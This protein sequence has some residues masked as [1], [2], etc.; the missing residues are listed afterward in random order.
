M[1]RT[2][3][4]VLGVAAALCVGLAIAGIGLRGDG[5]APAR[6]KG[7]SP[8]QA[9]AAGGG[10]RPA[11][12]DPARRGEPDGGADDVAGEAVEV[13]TRVEERVPGQPRTHGE[14]VG[15]AVVEG[16]PPA[17]PY[18]PTAEQLAADAAYVAVRER[19]AAEVGTQ[20]AA[21]RSALARACPG[22]EEAAGEFSVSASFDAAGTLVGM[23]ISEVGE[24][25]AAVGQ[26]LRSQAIALSVAPGQQGVTVDVPLR[27]R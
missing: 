25:D 21:Q 3:L 18:E 22:G 13:R 9:L 7:A 10:V 23:G 14:D 8:T 12:V 6:Q 2:G 15:E 24:V 20:L 1:T 26:C 4:I 5:E 19:A 27:L 11:E 17:P 16:T